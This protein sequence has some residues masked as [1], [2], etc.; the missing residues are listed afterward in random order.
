MEHFIQFLHD[1]R[2]EQM[3]PDIVHQAKRCLLDWSG[4]AIGGL[5]DQATQILI[6]TVKYLGGNEQA[7]L[8][9]TQTKTSLFNAALVHGTMSHILDYDDTCL[10][11]L[12]HPSVCVIPALIAYGEWKKSSGREFLLSLILGIE[13]E[14]RISKAM[15]ASHYDRGWH[16][17]STMGRFGA[18]AGVGKM[19][20]LTTARLIYALGIAGSQ[21]S[22]IRMAFGT[23]TKSFHSG[24]AAA[25]GLLAVLLAER[26]Y[27][28]PENIIEGE[29]G[30]GSLFSGDFSY[31]RGFGSL[32][33][34][35][36]IMGISFKPYPSCLYTHPLIYGIIQLRNT[37]H[38]QP[39]E[40]KKVEC[41]VSR[42]CQDNAC[43]T[44]MDSALDL[45][46]NSSYCAA[47]ALLEGR[48]GID[49]FQDECGKNKNILKC[50]EKVS[51]S[52]N[53][54]LN[55]SEAEVCIHLNDGQ[56]Y[57]C[58]VEHPLGDPW[59]PL[60]D[61]ALEKK[62]RD[63]LAL[64]FSPRR[65]DE[66]VTTVWNFESVQNIEEFANLFRK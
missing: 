26:G 4:V 16:S 35:Y 37:H 64:Q 6:D 56:S 46:F 36:N 5:E 14:T 33:Q 19:A 25:D 50:T 66:I 13:A 58:H 41:C 12:L 11:A 20:E 61:E 53:P 59:N 39:E 42:F 1:S 65:I 45:K 23:M 24:K 3:R 15:G 47:I 57:S 40:V 54:A 48:A 2:F 27:T 22:G 8:Y 52:L 21:S 7:S 29:K 43:K 9:G 18:A 17:T 38:I 30:L 44:S 55:D 31:E 51:I 49:L 34:E 62:A 10:G 63:L 28:A 60:D 32:G